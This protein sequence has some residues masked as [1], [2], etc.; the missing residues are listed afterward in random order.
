MKKIIYGALF[1]ILPLLGFIVGLN[2]R[3]TKD[4]YITLVGIES[5]TK[6]GYRY[7]EFKCNPELKIGDCSSRIAKNYQFLTEDWR[8][9]CISILTDIQS[10]LQ[11][12]TSVVQIPKSNFTTEKTNCRQFTDGSLHCYTTNNQY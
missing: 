5:D 6:G 7:N 12:S 3:E 1:V 8:N 4:P 9:R 2:L 10:S 11:K